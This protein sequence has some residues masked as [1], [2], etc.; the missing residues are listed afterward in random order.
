MI[1][2]RLR[3]LLN[4]HI[5]FVAG[6][7]NVLFVL[8]AVGSR[9]GYLPGLHLHESV[10]LLPYL[11]C[12]AAAF[13]LSSHFLHKQSG[14]YHRLTWIDAAWLSTRQVIVIA[15]LVFTLAFITQD[16]DVSRVLLGL[17]LAITWIVLLGLNMWLPQI[18]THILFGPDRKVPTLFIGSTRGMHRL[19]YWLTSKKSVGLHPVG[20]LSSEDRPSRETSP[21]WLGE[22]SD[23]HSR[24]V[25]HGVVQVIV[26]ELPA[27]RGE[28]RGIVEVCQRAGCRL[29]IYTNLEDVF[30]HPLTTVNEEGHQFQSLQAEPL[31]DPQNRLLKRALD[32]AVSLPVVLVLLPPLCT[33]V[34]LMQH[35]QAPGPLFF[36]QE[37][38]GHGSHSFFMFKFR[39]MYCRPSDVH[40]EAKQ[41]TLKDPR[42]YPFGSFLRKSSLDE[43]PQFFNILRGDMS[44][45]G[46]RPHMPL[47]DR[48]FARLAKPYR[49]RF[50]VK[51]GLTGL[52]QCRGYRGEISDPEMLRTRVQ[53]DLAYITQWSIWMDL[54]IIAKTGWQILFPPK[55]AY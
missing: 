53:H 21:P 8:F 18:L 13:W 55:S 26:V 11:L 30:Q 29:L 14:R 5:L 47:H 34:W 7:A 1:A 2:Q 12:I 48:Q 15:A 28:A 10:L 49:T 51:P 9:M 27:T 50:F 44:L 42:I 40:E 33:L 45:V 20:F 25:E 17:Y 19:D 36:K 23:L 54:H 32:I 46:P 6:V 43:F 38:T 4:L 24:I 39:S 52:A 22:L 35:R 31:E 3:G 41:A 37:R 16:R